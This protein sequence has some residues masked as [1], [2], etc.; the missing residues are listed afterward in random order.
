VDAIR[1]RIFM[2]RTM[3]NALSKLKTMDDLQIQTWLSRV[4]KSGVIKLVYAMLG[5]DD[6][7]NSRVFRNLS[8]CAGDVLKAELKKYRKLD[9]NV[10]VINDTSDNLEKL[11]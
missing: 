10:S 4:E 11:M 2:E 3:T 6:E 5:V 8:S 9:V 7:V 1:E